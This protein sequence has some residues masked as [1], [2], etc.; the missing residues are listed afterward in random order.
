M[1]WVPWLLQILG[2]LDLGNDGKEGEYTVMDWLWYA[3]GVMIFC[4]YKLL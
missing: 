3:V 4:N 1:R 2:N